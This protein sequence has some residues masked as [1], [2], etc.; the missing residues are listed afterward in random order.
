MPLWRLQCLLNLKRY[1]FHSIQIL[2]LL[3]L[4][5]KESSSTN[6]FDNLPALL[7]PPKMTF[8]DDLDRY[9]NTNPEDIKDPFGG[10]MNINIFILTSIAWLW[11]IFQSWVSFCHAC[12]CQF[13]SSTEMKLKLHL[14]T[15]NMYLVKAKFCSPISIVGSLSNQHMHLCVLEFGACWGM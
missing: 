1:V 7:A 12:S 4:F 2:F 15:L 5:Q 13:S 10:G 9:L 14:Y 8:Q 6:I 11:T 3:H